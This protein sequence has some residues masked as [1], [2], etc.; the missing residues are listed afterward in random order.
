[1]W[2]SVKQP[3]FLKLGT[4]ELLITIPVNQIKFLGG[5]NSNPTQAAVGKV[6][7]KLSPK[8]GR[9][10]VENAQR[11]HGGQDLNPGPTTC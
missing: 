4:F 3:C 2:K 9:K 8:G 5:P 6:W 1:M 11:I 7:K 10:G